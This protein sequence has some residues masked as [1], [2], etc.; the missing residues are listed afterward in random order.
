MNGRMR[1]LVLLVVGGLL[2]GASCRGCGDGCCCAGCSPEQGCTCAGCRAGPET[3]C[4]CVGCSARG[5]PL[6]APTMVQCALQTALH[7]DEAVASF[8]CGAPVT[9]L[10]GLELLHEGWWAFN[11]VPWLY[12]DSLSVTVRGSP[13]A[14]TAGATLPEHCTARLRV[15]SQWTERPGS[16]NDLWG[17][18]GIKVVGVDT[19]GVAMAALEGP[20]REHLRQA[21]TLARSMCGVSALGLVDTKLRYEAPDRVHVAGTPRMR[22]GVDVPEALVCLGVVVLSVKVVEL[23]GEM[24]LIL[25]DVTLEEVDTPGVDWHKPSDHDWD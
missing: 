9:G 8:V 3:G 6:P 25:H 16:C 1:L 20:L 2:A 23:A 21:A 11:A 12:E 7:D 4:S 13:R 5:L 15:A 17:L 18:K 14:P 10:K 24:K 22:S 19:P